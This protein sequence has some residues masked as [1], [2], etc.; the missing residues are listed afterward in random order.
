MK[1]RKLHIKLNNESFTTLGEFDNNTFTYYESNKL[2]SKMIIDLNNETLIKENIDYKISLDF[3][4]NNEIYLKKEDGKINLDIKLL[5][6]EK[7]E[8]KVIINYQIVDSKEEVLLE[9]KVI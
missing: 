3:N 4:K 1:K 2:R 9:I 8:E 7:E 5:K 6:F